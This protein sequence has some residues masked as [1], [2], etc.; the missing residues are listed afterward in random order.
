MVVP[1]GQST[2]KKRVAN[3][4]IA[5]IFA[6]SALTG[7]VSQYMLSLVII[8]CLGI[9]LIVDE[10]YLAFP[11]ILF[12]N[13]LYG[14]VMGI[15]VLRIYTILLLFSCILRLSSLMKINIKN[16]PPLII[17]FMFLS[18]VMTQHNIKTAVF[19][20]VDIICCVLIITQLKSDEKLKRF[21]TLF[22]LVAF[23]AFLTGVIGGNTLE[24]IDMGGEDEVSR[25]MATFEDPN[26]MGFFYTIAVFSVVTLKLFTP[27]TR[28][29]IVIALYAMM[30]TSL[31]ITAIIINI[32]TWLIYLV[33]TKRLGIKNFVLIIAVILLAYG[34]YSY[35]LENRD[36]P[37]IGDLVY[38]IDIKLGELQANN[39][40]AATTNRTD[41]S[42]E[43][44]Q[45]FLNSSLTKMLLGGTSVNAFYIH[46]DLRAAAHNE[47]IDLLINVGLIGTFFMLGY[48]FLN[49]I[50]YK[51]FYTRTKENRF[52][53]LFIGKTIWILYAFTLTMFLDYRFTLFFLL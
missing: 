5:V 13:N 44:F 33:V 49:T 24:Q 7:V 42:K 30:L 46:P 41:L 26:Y 43:H 36:A 52:L 14:V 28:V 27:K 45:Y 20:F 37:V 32:I 39:I 50:K 8:G 51:S 40:N 6:C 10:L 4:V 9:L 19:A 21:F 47:Y 16:L 34:L 11:F 53:F 29:L 3:C 31:S 17:Y 22:A 48:L 1:N 12:Y 15:S 18:L 35:G 25:F 2:A 38:R 23:V